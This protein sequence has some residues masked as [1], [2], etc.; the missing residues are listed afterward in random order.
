MQMNTQGPEHYPLV[1]NQY[2]K[3]GHMV[4][5][6]K[7]CGLV[8]GGKGVYFR[9]FAKVFLGKNALLG[10]NFTQKIQAKGWDHLM[11]AVEV[12][13]DRDLNP[14][15]FEK[16]RKCEERNKTKQIEFLS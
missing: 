1:P 12:G 16:G 9:I 11:H 13:R 15:P 6:L 10:W 2:K 7:W 4:K 8:V 14:F 3:G 5:G